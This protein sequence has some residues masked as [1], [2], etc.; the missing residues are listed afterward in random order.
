MQTNSRRIRLLSISLIVILATIASAYLFLPKLLD[1]DNYKEQIISEIQKALK[2]PVSY[3]SGKFTFNFGPA[4][5]FDS[6]VVKEP[7]SAETFLSARR[8]ICRLD[9]IPLLRKKMVIHSLL[10]EKPDIR[11]V[12]GLD[13]KLN[14]SDLF[15]G[16]EQEGMP[17]EVGHLRIKNGTITF[18]D[19]FFQQEEVV[20]KLSDTDLSL[21]KLTRGA[22]S[23]FKLSAELGG[24]ASGSF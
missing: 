15:E 21:E 18:H 13:G 17:L 14:I 1:L 16:G 2:R 3:S 6:V 11:I 20:T 5:S 24:G 9:L 22:K 12:R 7:D 23:A 10:A 4:F 8:V 19:R